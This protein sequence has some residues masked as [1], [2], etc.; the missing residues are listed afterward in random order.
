MANFEKT[1]KV[2]VVDDSA[3]MRKMI[4]DILS[5]HEQ[6]TVAGIAMNGQMAINKLDVLKPDVITLDIDMPFMN[7]IETLK[8]IQ[9]IR[10]T[11][12]IMFSSLTKAGAEITLQALE[13][14]AMDFVQKPN[15]NNPENLKK[16]E[17]ELINK[18]L[19]AK[20][21]H[22]PNFQKKLT[23]QII[24]IPASKTTH[25]VSKMK[26]VIIGSSTGGPQ[27]LKEV[28]PFLPGDLPAQYLIVQHMPPK[29]TDLLAQRL[30]KISNITVKE[31]QEGDILEAKT[32]LL[33]PGNYHMCVD[34]GKIRLNQEPPVWGVRPSVDLTLASAA[35]IY[36]EDLICVILTGMGHDGLNGAK[37]V[38]E[39][40]GYCIAEDKSTCVIYG[41]P[42]NVIE[43]GYADEIV[44]LDKIGASIVNAVYR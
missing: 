21:M 30:D 24:N 43:A 17:T 8:E 28:I 32:A 41:M 4:T 1:I 29:F 13:L 44:P 23:P 22:Q 5:S 15:S 26:T 34:G 16:I 2:L 7:G 19:L 9:R 36:K 31:A 6:I 38:K 12:T 33:A 42:K 39:F 10:P 20:E 11:P 35:K 27:A 14:G 3:L 25:K 37:A 18:V 40:G